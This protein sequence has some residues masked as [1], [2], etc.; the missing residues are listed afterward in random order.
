MLKATQFGLT[1]TQGEGYGNV[2]S[3]YTFFNLNTL[4]TITHPFLRSFQKKKWNLKE[5]THTYR[6]N[7]PLF[8]LKLYTLR[9]FLGARDKAKASNVKIMKSIKTACYFYFMGKI[10]IA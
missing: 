5:K 7:C 6:Q 3:F 1:G 10:V 4:H 8:S 2:A 9:K